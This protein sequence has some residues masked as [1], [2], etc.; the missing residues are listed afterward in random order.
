MARKNS[1][2][3]KKNNSL[4]A[5]IEIGGNVDTGGGDIS[6]GNIAKGNVSMYHASEMRISEVNN[7]FQPIYDKLNHLPKLLPKN[8]RILQKNVVEIQYEVSKGKKAD[9][10]FIESRLAN[11]AHMAPDILEIVI[12]TLANPIIGL[13]DLVNKIAEKASQVNDKDVKKNE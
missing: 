2:S 5:N 8:R 10:G 12:S 6:G 7:L 1:K 9:K 13:R 11:I 4:G 3:Q